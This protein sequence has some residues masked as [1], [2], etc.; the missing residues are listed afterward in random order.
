M[1]AKLFSILASASIV[2]AMSCNNGEQTAVTKDSTSTT[3]TEGATLTTTEQLPSSTIRTVQLNP[4]TSYVDLTT[5]KS[6]QLRVDT[7]TKY[8]I[9]EVTKQPVMFY[10]DPSTRDTFDRQGRLVNRAL[11]RGTSGDYTI[12][13]SLLTS[14]NDAGTDEASSSSDTGTMSVTTG[15]TGNSKEKIKDDKYK[16]KDDNSKVKV[17]EDKTKIKTRE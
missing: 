12:D 14:G 4:N 1:K 15:T 8:I 2:T 7:V 3:T 6:V 17:K 9:N 5:G 11:R 16:Y 10:I 13:E